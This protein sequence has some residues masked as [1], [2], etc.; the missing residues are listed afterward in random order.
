MEQYWKAIVQ[1]MLEAGLTPEEIQQS[2]YAHYPDNKPLHDTIN[3]LLTRLYAKVKGFCKRAQGVDPGGG[4]QS[5]FSVPNSEGEIGPGTNIDAT[6]EHA[7]S[8]SYTDHAR[9]R[10]HMKKQKEEEEL[11][12]KRKKRKE[13][14]DRLGTKPG[15]FLR[16]KKPEIPGTEDALWWGKLQQDIKNKKR[17]QPADDQLDDRPISPEVDKDH[18]KTQDTMKNTKKE[19]EDAKKLVDNQSKEIKDTVEETEDSV[20]QLKDSLTDLLG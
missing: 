7:M 3:N 8:G 10:L 13:L 20:N 9:H 4:F 16:G 15:E 11:K 2:F 18:T 14:L 12:Q 19:M 6:D 1:D 5:N 17:P